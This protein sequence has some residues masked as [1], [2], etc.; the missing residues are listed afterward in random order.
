M[1][2]GVDGDQHE[3]CPWSLR[4]CTIA[5]PSSLRKGATPDFHNP[6]R[7]Q[8]E[9]SDG[10]LGADQAAG[11]STANQTFAS[12]SSDTQVA[13]PAHS[14][15]RGPRTASR[16]N[17]ASCPHVRAIAGIDCCR[18]GA[19][20]IGSRR[21]AVLVRN[22]R[23]DRVRR[24]RSGACP[25]FRDRRS[26]VLGR[27]GSLCTTA[28]SRPLHGE[29]APRPRARG[30]SRIAARLVP[31]G[32]GDGSSRV[33]P[34]AELALLHAERRGADGRAGDFGRAHASDEASRSDH[35]RGRPVGGS[36]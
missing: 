35:P 22:R 12:W 20:A 30:S 23:C 28:G 1:C 36:G 2:S 33:S 24:T 25:R 21:D 9:M 18:F 5:K 31:S 8:H 6:A 16:R 29:R 17:P 11:G 3:R 4:G 14:S 15:R 10:E 32:G 7:K 34:V 19:P 26:G 27:A 13:V